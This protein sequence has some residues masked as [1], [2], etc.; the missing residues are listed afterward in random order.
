MTLTV[1]ETDAKN[2]SA[3]TITLI[4]TKL[5]TPQSNS[6]L[7]NRPELIERLKQNQA[8]KVTL[9]SAPAGYGKTTL[10]TQ[11]L[12]TKGKITLQTQPGCR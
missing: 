7:I 9:V 5:R 4:S 12:D 1:P 10:V 3:D 2:I 6:D 11:W 8:R